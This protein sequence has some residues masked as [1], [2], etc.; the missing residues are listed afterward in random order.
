MNEL[1]H[2]R[3]SRHA[4]GRVMSR[5]L[6]R[7]AACALLAACGDDSLANSTPSTP[8]GIVVLDGYIQ[9]GLTL[10]TRILYGA[11]S[12]AAQRVNWATAPFAML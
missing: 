2:T 1:Q 11:R 9:P 5:A 10:F 6:T 4:I 3:V 7:G 8:K 12:R